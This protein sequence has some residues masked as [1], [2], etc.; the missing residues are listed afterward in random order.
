MP[1]K[2]QPSPPRCLNGLVSGRESTNLVR[3]PDGELELRFLLAVQQRVPR[4]GAE[5]HHIVL[6]AP[7]TDLARSYIGLRPGTPLHVHGEWRKRGRVA[8]LVTSR[9]YQPAPIPAPD[10]SRQVAAVR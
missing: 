10:N 7:G 6:R 1:K 8:E 3:T 4:G 5:Y 9:L 2:L